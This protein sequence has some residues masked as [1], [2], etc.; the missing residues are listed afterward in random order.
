ASKV[1]GSHILRFGVGVNRILGGGFASFFGLAP[2][3]FTATNSGSNVNDVLTYPFLLAILGNGQGFF[4][5]TPQFGYP[6]GGQ[7]DTRF[8]AYV[9]DSWKIKPNFTL[10]YGLRYNRDTGRSD[11]DL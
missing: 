6:G 9:G 1:W 7:A 3:D 8:Q 11:S 4:T 10:S 2:F 5:E